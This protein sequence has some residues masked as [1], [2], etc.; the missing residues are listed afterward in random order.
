MEQ[1][2]QVI[3]SRSRQTKT[4]VMAGKK[5]FNLS[6]Q[7]KFNVGKEKGLESEI[8]NIYKKHRGKEKEK[9]R[10]PTS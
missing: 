4:K 10:I 9:E 8:S 7:A 5:K 1:R 3:Q 6:T 2:L